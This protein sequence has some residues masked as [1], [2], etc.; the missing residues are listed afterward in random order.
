MLTRPSLDWSD[1]S[2]VIQTVRFLVLSSSA[3]SSRLRSHRVGGV[4]VCEIEPSNL[5]QIGRLFDSLA[6]LL[7]KYPRL[8]EEGHMVFVS[9]CE[10]I[11][12]PHMAPYPRVS[13]L[14]SCH[15]RF[16]SPSHDSCAVCSESPVGWCL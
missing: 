6:T 3:I 15:R 13:T 4:R 5:H 8:V 9:G 7:S 16:L 12:P 10:S 11:H 1:C 2:T 14:R